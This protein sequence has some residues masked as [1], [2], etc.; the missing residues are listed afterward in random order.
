MVRIDKFGNLAVNRNR[1][2]D[3]AFVYSLAKSILEISVHIDSENYE[4]AIERI[5]R[6]YPFSL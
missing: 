1:F 2:D 3:L 6:E 4:A 5:G